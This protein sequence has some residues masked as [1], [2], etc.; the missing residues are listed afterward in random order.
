MNRF[1]VAYEKKKFFRTKGGKPSIVIW[2][3]NDTPYAKDIVD[4]LTSLQIPYVLK[5]RVEEQDLG[6]ADMV[7]FFENNPQY[8]ELAFR[9]LCVPVAPCFEKR[10]KDYNAVL[11]QGNGFYFHPENKWEVFTALIRACETFQFPYDWEN[12]LREIH[13]GS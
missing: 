8:Y 9:H 11:E 4:A 12:L 7:I 1:A 6:K 5:N 13:K 2:H 10:T 3:T